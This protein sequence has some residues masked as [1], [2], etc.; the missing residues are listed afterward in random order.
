M[1]PSK[2]Q[3]NWAKKALSSSMLSLSSSGYWNHHLLSLGM[4]SAR[5]RP[6]NSS[7][8]TLSFLVSPRVAMLSGRFKVVL[9]TDRN[10]V[11]D[12]L[13]EAQMIRLRRP[14]GGRRHHLSYMLKDPQ[15]QMGCSL[16]RNPGMRDIS[17]GRCEG[18]FNYI[19]Y[20]ALVAIVFHIGE[21]HGASVGPTPQLQPFV[22]RLVEA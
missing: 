22:H 13:E 20:W 18:G 4:T 17:R 5:T 14:L 7:S 9:C 2:P 15:L 19:Q 16:P 8:S 1:L 3:V 11:K 21:R 10:F 12:Q 6:S